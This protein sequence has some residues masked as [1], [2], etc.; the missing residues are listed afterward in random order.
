MILIRCCNN[1]QNIAI[2]TAGT[3]GAYNPTRESQPDIRGQ[4]NT[5]SV[6]AAAAK[7]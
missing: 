1:R 7:E 5:R 4:W 3:I 2:F 6:F